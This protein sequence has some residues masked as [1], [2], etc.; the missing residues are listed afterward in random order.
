MEISV[1]PFSHSHI[2]CLSPTHLLEEAVIHR[3]PRLVRHR[4]RRDHC[5]HKK[6]RPSPH[7]LSYCEANLTVPQPGPHVEHGN[8]GQV[9]VGRTCGAAFL[10][11]RVNGVEDV[12]AT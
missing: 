4:V 11:A 2:L 3:L 5:S 1:V 6:T 7:I 12:R 9:K 8:Q 10:R